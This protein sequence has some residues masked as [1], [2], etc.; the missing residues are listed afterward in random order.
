MKPASFVVTLQ[1][2]TVLDWSE[3]VV[4]SVTR[5]QSSTDE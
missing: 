2:L 4:L 3:K 5:A 1:Y